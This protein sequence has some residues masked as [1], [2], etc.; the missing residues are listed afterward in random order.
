MTRAEASVEVEAPPQRVWEVASDPANLPN[1]EKHIEHVDLPPGGLGPGARY[2]VVM[3]FMGVR[4]KIRAEVLE[5]EP[6]W[7]SKIKLSGPLEAVVTT[8]IAS[9]PFG[10]S[11]LRHEVEYR[12]R[13][14]LGSVSARGL[15]AVGGSQIAL[16]RGALAQKHEAERAERRGR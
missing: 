8:S 15:N 7:L 14:L 2:S 12:F 1:W 3:R 13:G 6:P 16:R 4:A 9:L 5:W 11:V 10:R